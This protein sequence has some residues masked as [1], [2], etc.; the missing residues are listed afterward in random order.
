LHKTI[1]LPLLTTPAHRHWHTDTYARTE[2]SMRAHTQSCAH[3]HALPY[4]RRWQLPRTY[5]YIPN[6]IYNNGA[7]M[8]TDA[9]LQMHTSTGICQHTHATSNLHARTH[10]HTDNWHLR[11]HTLTHILARTYA[12]SKVH[13]C[14]HTNTC[15]PANTH[16]RAHTYTHAHTTPQIRLSSN[17]RLRH[18]TKGG[19]L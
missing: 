18:S 8:R 11:A 19:G 6:Q 16:T 10:N 7:Q 2:T 12:P 4:S 17:L 5:L 1:C 9:F 15:T 14:T 13:P 3:T